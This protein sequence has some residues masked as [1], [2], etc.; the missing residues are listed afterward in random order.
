MRVIVAE[1]YD[2]LS[3]QAADFFAGLIAENPLANVM[4]ATGNTPM[5]MYRALAAR[6]ERG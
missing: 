4:P 2:A 3:E 1:N 6:K 5:G